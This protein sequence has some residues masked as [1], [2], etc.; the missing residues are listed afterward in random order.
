M[1]DRPRFD[2]HILTPTLQVTGQAEPVGPWLD[3]LNNRDKH[4][5]TV[6]HARV[7]SI[8]VAAAPVDRPQL[9]MIRDQVSMIALLGSSARDGI[10]MV[11]NSVMAIIHI[12]PIVCRGEIHLGVDTPLA[13]YFD[14]LAGNYFPVTNADLHALSPLPVLLPAKVDI[15]LINRSMVQAYYPA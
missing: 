2:A 15:A 4:T 8:G 10:T 6:H 5:F 1:P 12:G 7:M 11:R 13:I 9:F 3:F 14:D